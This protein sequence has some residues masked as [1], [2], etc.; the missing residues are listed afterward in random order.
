VR[1]EGREGPR[2]VHW[3]EAQLVPLPDGNIFGV[4]ADTYGPMVTDGY[5]LMLAPL[6]AGAHTIHFTASL[7]GGFHLDVTYHL[8]VQK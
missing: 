6:S 1:N 4:P 3:A 7:G 2:Q 5:Y 8:T